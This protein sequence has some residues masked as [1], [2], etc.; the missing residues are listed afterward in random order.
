MWDRMIDWLKKLF[1]IEVQEDKNPAE[2]DAAKYEYTGGS[3]ENMTAIIAGKLANLVFGD[4]TISIT[5]EDGSAE[6]ERVQMIGDVLERLFCDE[7]IRI[8]SQVFGKGGKVLVPYVAGRGIRIAAI[9]Q[10]R[11]HISRMSGRE[12][13]AVTILLDSAMRNKVRCYLLAEYDLQ[14]TTLT[15]TYRG[16]DD[17]GSEIAIAAVPEWAGISEE[18]T[19]TNVEHLPMAHIKCPKD[20]R[21]GNEKYGVPIT[22]GCDGIIRELEEHIAIYRRE[23][24]LTRP[25]LGLDAT[26]F[27]RAATDGKALDIRDIR[28]TVQDGDDPFIPME[29]SSLDS[30][31]QWSLYAPDIRQTAMEERYQSILRRLERACGLSQGVLT[32]R[33]AQLSYANRD[34]VRAAQYDTFTVISSMRDAW[35][36][37]LDR[38]AEACDVLAERFGLTAAGSRRQYAIAFDWDTSLIESTEQAFAQMSELQQRGMV[39]KPELRAWVMGGSVQ[40][41]EAA[42]KDMQEAGGDNDVVGSILRGIRGQDEE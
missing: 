22:Y 31:K 32:E 25:M 34:E 4:S 16:I 23:Y 5:M 20:D 19:I 42:I 12:M 28:K 17:N 24:M 13:Q 29:G 7:G 1:G 41:A 2:K 26:L 38:L 14:G 6:S 30:G 27:R 21:R 33:S 37:A 8:T 40:D 18:I 35:E 3:G 39:S 10:T 9:D 15:I 36:H 11:M